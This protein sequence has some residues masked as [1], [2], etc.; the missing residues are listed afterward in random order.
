LTITPKPIEKNPNPSKLEKPIIIKEIIKIK[1]PK[2]QQL[3]MP[4]KMLIL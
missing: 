1:A 2:R 3:I 4:N